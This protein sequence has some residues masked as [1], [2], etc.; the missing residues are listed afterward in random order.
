MSPLI[1]TMSERFDFTRRDFLKL[2]GV[3]AAAA[4]AGCAKPPQD[5][6]IPY[7]IPPKDILP[8]VPYW[9]ASTCRECPA[10]C[11]VLVKTREGRAIKIEGNPAH[12]V[13]HGGLC[14]RGHAA[15]QGLYDPDRVKRPMRRRA[16]PGRRS[17]GTRRSSSP[18]ERI[19]AARGSRRSRSLTD[20]HPGSLE[21]CSRSGPRR[22][23]GTHLVYEPFS[24]ATAARGQPQRTFG[25]AA[26]PAYDLAR[27]RCIVSFGADFLET[28][29]S[30]AG[31]ARGFAAM[32]G[33]HDDSVFVTVEPRLSLTGA[34]ADEWIA[35][36]PGGEMALALGM[37]G[38]IVAENLGAGGDRGALAEATSAYTPEA[39]QQQTDV[40]ADTVRRLAAHVRAP[41][42]PA[43]ALAGGIASQSEQSVAMLAA[44]NL[45]NHVGRRRSA[46]RCAST[47]RPTTTRSGP[48]PTS[49]SSRRR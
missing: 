47:A 19:G 10:G 41:K 34:N 5:R 13:N 44:V 24:P 38:V 48:S 14:S 43:V 28:F 21:R 17:P 31:H 2:A 40:P 23:G 30:P 18:G 8:G 16:E 11:G 37:A 45:L 26:V 22:A 46:T 32:R 3:G 9:Y 7:L 15:L 35:I 36:R 49:S 27:A 25:V 29:G 42:R 6:L 1:G 33:R 20:H 12:P 39:V 4:V